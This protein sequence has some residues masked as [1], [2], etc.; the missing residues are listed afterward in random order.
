MAKKTSA[1][2]LEG[3][4]ELDAA[5]K[6]VGN[7]TTGLLL[8]QAVQVGAQP[9]VDE[10]KRLAPKRT[11]ALAESIQQQDGKMQQGR[12]NID[13]SY[14]R[15]RWYGGLIERGTSKMAA[16]PYL[17]PALEAKAQEATDA[18]GAFLRDALKGVLA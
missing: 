10:A 17:R 3:F 13:V 15:K 12:A 1:V 7:R 5:L 8:K 11:G 16:K 18:I 2:Y 4:D 9:I 14:G 6:E